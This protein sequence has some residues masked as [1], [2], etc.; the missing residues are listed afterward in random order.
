[1]SLVAAAPC[2]TLNKKRNRKPNPMKPKSLNLLL[3]I[4]ATVLA[5]QAQGQAQNSLQ[6]FWNSPERRCGDYASSWTG[7][8]KVVNG[9]GYVAQAAGLY[10]TYNAVRNTANL[11]G[12]QACYQTAQDAYRT[13]ASPGRAADGYVQMYRNYNNT[14]SPWLFRR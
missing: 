1:M 10:K 13:A 8:K 9:V 5:S 2:M 7:P 3:S 14:G 11:S 4:L 12:P 6:R